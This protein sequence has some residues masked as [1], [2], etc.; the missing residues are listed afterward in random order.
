[1]EMAHQLKDRREES[2]ADPSNY[3]IPLEPYRNQQWFDKERENI[4]RRAWLLIGRVEEVPKPGDYVVK[5]VEVLQASALIVHGK[6]GEIRAFHNVCPHRANQVVWDDKGSTPVFVCKYHNWAFNTDGKVRAIPDEEAFAHVDKDRCGLP[7]INMVIWDGWIFLNFAHTPEISLDEFLG[8]MKDY[9]SGVEYI[10]AE[11]PIVIQANLKCNWKVVADAFAEAYH[12][13]AIH[14]K[15]LKTRFSNQDNPFGRPLMLAEV[16][17]HG[18]NSMFG[19]T[20]FAPTPGQPVEAL[21]YGPGKRSEEAL[22]DMARFAEHQ[23]VN[24]TKTKAWSMDVNYI[25]PNTNLDFN[26]LGFF[27]HQFWPVAL[28]ETR[29]EARFYVGKAHNIRDRFSIEHRMALAVDIVLEDLS[30]V[31]R[32]QRGINSGASEFMNISDSE[33]LIRTQT[34]HIAAWVNA[35]SAKEALNVSDSAK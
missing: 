25:F 13:P 7:P 1:M 28:N 8:G 3:Q 4:F 24:P 21:L 18:V 20:E 35:P 33:L 26:P 16:A 12:I 19:N 9:L 17:P 30:N 32:T 11:A 15:S 31:E 6:D 2:L 5:Q 27:S 10:N 22:A 23:A 34:D 29:H 14:A